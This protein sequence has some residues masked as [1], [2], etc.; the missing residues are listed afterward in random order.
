MILDDHQVTGVVDRVAERVGVDRLHRVGIDHADPDP[1]AREPVGGLEA[2]DERDA[3]AH[4][5]RRASSSEDRRVLLPPIG[6]SSSGPYRQ[7][8]FSRVVRR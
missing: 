4:Q 7:G 5:G 8:V 3:G 1:F 6:N 2:L